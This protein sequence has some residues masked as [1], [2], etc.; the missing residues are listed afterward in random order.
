[1]LTDLLKMRRYVAY[2]LPQFWRSMGFWRGSVTAWRL[3]EIGIGKGVRYRIRAPG[4]KEPLWLRAATSDRTVFY[5]IFV[6][7][8]LDFGLFPSPSVIV[9]A[10]ANIGCASV[11]LASKY[12]SATVLAIE[13]DVK[14]FE[15]LRLN[16]APYPQIKALHAA[17][18][19]DSGRVSAANPGADLDALRARPASADDIDTI[20]TITMSEII[21]EYRSVDLLKLDIEG[22]ERELFS[23]TDLD[24]LDSVNCIAVELHDWCISGCTEALRA[25]L[26]SRRSTS[27]QSGQY[28]LV[29]LH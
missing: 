25:A 10:G 27:D 20:S 15:T 19:P 13:F 7:R 22:G 28:M 6:L 2:Y 16:L 4:I 1:M 21:A 11:F 26:T 29:R 9:D 3:L 18:W 23:A 14:N 5:Q 12:P 8:E 17:L 24:W